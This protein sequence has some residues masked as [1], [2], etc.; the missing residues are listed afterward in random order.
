[1]KMTIPTTL[2]AGTAGALTDWLEQLVNAIYPDNAIEWWNAGRH[3]RIGRE[4]SNG[5]Q[6]RE[7]LPETVHH[8]GAYVRLGNC[9]GYVLE[10]VLSP[11]QPHCGPEVLRCLCSAKFLGSR[12]QAWEVAMSVSEALEDI[13]CY[14]RQSIVTDLFDKLPK[15]NY[16]WARETTLRGQVLVEAAEQQEGSWR[17][18]LHD[19]QG[20]LVD[21]RHAPDKWAAQ[22]LLED[23]RIVLDAQH[24]MHGGIT[25]I[26]KWETL[27]VN[28]QALTA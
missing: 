9:E 11:Y 8:V 19:E 15:E 10:V 23:W 14:H 13:L 5:Y 26:Y 6:A 25:P 18:S 7:Q 27:N 16:S 22:A 28:E 2:H 17:V 20:N 21:E 24:R 1:M 12:A 3:E 4:H